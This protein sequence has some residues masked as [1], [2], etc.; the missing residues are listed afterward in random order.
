MLLCFSLCS[1]DSGIRP[2]TLLQFIV[3]SKVTLFP[4]KF[5]TFIFKAIIKHI[6]LSKM[7]IT[8]SQ[9]A[10]LHKVIGSEQKL[11][12]YIVLLLIMKKLCLMRQK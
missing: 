9:T 7:H 3:I 1:R 8:N 11:V 6:L 4:F 10:Q 2:S 5:V 12:A